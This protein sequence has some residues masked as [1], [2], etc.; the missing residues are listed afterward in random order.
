MSATHTRASP[1][2]THSNSRLMTPQHS[3][4]KTSRSAYSKLSP[5]LPVFYTEDDPSA[6]H[7]VNKTDLGTAAQNA[8]AGALDE[9]ITALA[10]NL[11]LNWQNTSTSKTFLQFSRNVSQ[12]SLFKYVDTIGSAIGGEL[13]FLGTSLFQQKQHSRTSIT[14]RQLCKASITALTSK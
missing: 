14:E 4:A 8:N 12:A 2:I 3:L 7:R 11:Q 5:V 1:T 9:G 13:R 10:G 6:L